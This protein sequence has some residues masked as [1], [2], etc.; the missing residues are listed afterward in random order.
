MSLKA[1]HPALKEK[2]RVFKKLDDSRVSNMTFKLW[3]LNI[4]TYV[5]TKIRKSCYHEIRRER[6]STNT[7]MSETFA[8][9]PVR[10]QLK[11]NN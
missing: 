2:L 4:L 10:E 8:V 3:D 6:E 7:R 11:S 1:T 5:V 9:V